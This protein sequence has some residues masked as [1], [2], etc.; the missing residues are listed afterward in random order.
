ME[1]PTAIIL[2][3]HTYTITEER[4]H[5]QIPRG[6]LRRLGE[7]ENVKGVFYFSLTTPPAPLGFMADKKNNSQVRALRLVQ[8]CREKLFTGE[9]HHR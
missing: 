3:A 9:W 6:K 7:K 2:K 8:D 1:L 5:G 4:T